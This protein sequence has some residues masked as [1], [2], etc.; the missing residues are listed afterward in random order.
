MA[1]EPTAPPS[2]TSP[3][4]APSIGDSPTTFQTRADAFVA[5]I[6]TFYA[7]LVSLSSWVNTTATQV[8]NNA[9]EAAAS[10]STAT[11]KAGEALASANAAANSATEASGHSGDAQTFAAAAQAAA[12]VPSLS[13]QAGKFLAVKTDESGPE[14]QNVPDTSAIIPISKTVISGSP[15]AIDISLTGYKR[16]KV[17]IRSLDG[18]ASSY[19]IR[20]RFSADGGSSFYSTS[21]DYTNS[22]VIFSQDQGNNYFLDYIYISNAS[23]TADSGEAAGE[24]MTIDLDVIISDGSFYTSVNYLQCGLGNGIYG[25]GIVKNT[26]VMN[27]LRIYPSS[28]SWSDGEIH[29]YGIADGGA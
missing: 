21:G 29:V 19:T 7:Y 28:G 5:W 4:T 1:T 26:S 18:S 27:M 22:H 12:G 11:T 16:F 6:A 25:S 10:A 9:G 17:L 13:G 2:G 3:P 14:W 15:S 23:T 24:K 8:F 20:L